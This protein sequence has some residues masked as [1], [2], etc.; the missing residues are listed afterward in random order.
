MLS[1]S[2]ARTSGASHSR[3]GIVIDAVAV[4]FGSDLCHPNH[5]RIGIWYAAAITNRDRFR[6]LSRL[7]GTEVT[8][9]DEAM[10]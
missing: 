4:V 10:Y 8:Q 2:I 6:E 1:N 5:S 3:N 9:I 7:E